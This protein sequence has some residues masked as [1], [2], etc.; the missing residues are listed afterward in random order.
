RAGYRQQCF[1]LSPPRCEPP[2]VWI[3][4]HY[5]CGRER[6]CIPGYYTTECVPAEYGWVRHGCRS[7]YV[8]IHSEYRRQVWVPERFEYRETKV[9]VP[10][11]FEVAAYARAY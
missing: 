3:E 8:L 1:P 11:H 5:D 6:V 4:G 2:R 9:W 10:G 7:E